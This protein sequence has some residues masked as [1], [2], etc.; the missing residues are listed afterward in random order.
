MS[1]KLQGM[2][3]IAEVIREHY[4]VGEVELPHQLEAAHQRRHRKMVVQTSGGASW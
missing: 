1:T 4:D 3:V 2:E